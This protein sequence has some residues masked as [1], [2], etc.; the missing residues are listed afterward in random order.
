MYRAPAGVN[1]RNSSGGRFY[2]Q[3]LDGWRWE[4]SLLLVAFAG[5]TLWRLTIFVQW[6]A[7]PPVFTDGYAVPRFTL[8][9]PPSRLDVRLGAVQ[10]L[11]RH[12]DRTPLAPLS[13]E[14]IE[15]WQAL[16]PSKEWRLWLNRRTRPP[17]VVVIEHAS[18]WGALTQLGLEQMITLGTHLR[19]YLIETHHLLPGSMREVKDDGAKND[20]LAMRATYYLRAISS[21]QAVLGGIFPHPTMTAD[22]EREE[23]LEY[24]DTHRAS[25]DF[26][27]DSDAT[28]KL[29]VRN[30]AMESMIPDPGMWCPRMHELVRRDNCVDACIFLCTC[31]APFAQT[32]F[33]V[34]RRTSPSSVPM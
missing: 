31:V 32:L 29:E 22:E 3:P 12:G 20:I 2:H 28:L 15:A 8:A 25:E 7:K 34:K 9:H 17:D 21:A 23:L 18:V 1:R 6:L 30:K 27:F 5:M 33:F 14:P 11:H 10:V 19:R 4:T 13:D 16:L 24:F 26:R